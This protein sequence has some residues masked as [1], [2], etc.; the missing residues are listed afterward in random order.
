MRLTMSTVSSSADRGRLVARRPPGRR[1]NAGGTVT[2]GSCSSMNRAPFARAERRHAHQRPSRARRSPRPHSR[3]PTPPAPPR[4]RRSGS[5]TTSAPASSFA[6]SRPGRTARPAACPRRRSGSAAGRA[7]SA[8]V[9]RRPSS[10]SRR[11]SR[12][13]CSTS[14]SFTTAA[15]GWSPI[16]IG[17]P[18]RQRRF[19]APNAHAPSS[20]EVSA[21]RFRSRTVSC[22][23]GSTPARA[24]NAA[25]A[26]GDMCAEA[27]GL[28]VTLAAST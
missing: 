22:S 14:R 15:S 11:A 5:S 17:S 9:Q 28:S 13:I 10:R 1:M 6:S 20:S 23:V 21:S 3:P 27:V 19:R 7:I 4:R 16:A 12:T 25:P 2:P 26:T 24:T 8:P 18:E